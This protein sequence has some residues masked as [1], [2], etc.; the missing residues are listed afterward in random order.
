MHF[1]SVVYKVKIFSDVDIILLLLFSET[2]SLSKNLKDLYTNEDCWDTVLLVQGKEFKVHKVI[3]IARSPVFAAMF[4]HDTV[5]KQTG[6]V[7]IN[8]CDPDSFQLFLEYLYSGRL[9][10]MSSNSALHLYSTSDKYNVQELKTFCTKY[11][12]Q[13][14]TVQNVCD[15][16]TMADQYDDTSLLSS[17]QTFFNK[18][19]K[20]IL[21]TN[22]WVDLFKK[23]FRLANKLLV[24]MSNAKE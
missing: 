21:V 9:E 18:N 23:N 15:V 5:E 12:M 11:L 7:T 4:R 17:T 24:E 20:E 2:D 19:L 3:L 22:E 6:K 13:N 14:L 1:K 8:D 10:D 16:V